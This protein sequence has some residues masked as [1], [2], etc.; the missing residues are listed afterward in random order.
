[1][2]LGRFHRGYGR[3]VVLDGVVE[4]L[5][6]GGLLFCQWSV[7]LDIEFRAALHRHGIG[8]RGFRLGQLALGLVESCLKRP[9]V[10]LEEKLALL[11]ERALLITLPL[12]V[13][14]DLGPDV[15]IDQPV[16]RRADPFAKNRN[17]LLL[18]RATSTSGGPPGLRPCALLGPHGPNNQDNHD[19]AKH[20]G[21]G[22]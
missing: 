22:Y 5:L 15:S 21:A 16:G 11:D 8:E 3:K 7:A 6:A 14:C 19:Q 12:Q 10:D 13:P 18:N 1:M 9:G 2:G 4:I 20:S 17:I